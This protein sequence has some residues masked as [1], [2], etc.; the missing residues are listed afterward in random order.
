[1]ED[2][3]EYE[4][5]YNYENE[6]VESNLNSDNQISQIPNKTVDF[7]I[8]KN[9]EIIKKRDIIINKFIESSCL[10]YDEAELVLMKF[11]W[12]YDKLIDIWY[13][14]TEKI[15]IESHIE[16][17]PESIKDIS[18][19]IK[20]NNITG[21]F[22]PICFCDIEKDNFLSLKCNH[23]FCKDCFIEYINNKLL[24]QPMN[25]LETPCP[26]NGCNLYLTRTI[27]RKCI[28][29]KKMQKIFA[30]SVVYNFIRTNKEIKVCPNAYCNYSIRVQDSI[31]KEIICK[32]GYIFC[33]SC[34]EESH[35]PCN[36]E[37]VKKWNS[38]QKKLYKKYSDL[39]K[40][41]DGNL[42]YLDDYNWIKNNTK[43]CPKCQISIEKNQGCN[44]MVC[45]KEAGGCGYQFCW[46]CLG[47]WKHHNY[48]C[49][50]N[51]EK[52]INNELEDKELDRF[53]KYYKGWKIQEY[54]INFNEKIRNKIEEYKNDLVEE[55]NLVQDD[56]KFLEDA[57]ET[58]FNCNRLLK[59]IF[60]FGYFLKEN[61]NI[62]LF[63]Y[64]YHFLHY[65]NDLLLESIELEKLPN[66]IEIQD[67]NLFQK[68]FLEY[69][70]NTFSLIKLIETYKNNL[71]NE[72]DNNL[73][74]KID[75]N[76]II[77]NY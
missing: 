75:Y 13:D 67:K 12:N 60:I 38:F 52:K 1:M 11:N 64:N 39:I 48:N 17:S 57:L 54:N 14:D 29:E 46:N 18:K 23:N 37:M 15:K 5:E 25:I 22:C 76:R 47:S 19:F 10:N 65:Q 27:Y 35:I 31:A 62:T 45:Q 61:A 3:I 7:E 58:I 32:C 2:E 49:Y 72:I 70:D 20:N 26:L 44:H 53:I 43:K 30:K 33:F 50:K 77:Y 55:K 63:E 9:S 71:I 4:E 69:K 51:E 24:T 68:M 74:D 21:N 59:Y 42:K 41:R 40:T 6:C 28:T 16:Q 73:Y 56:V 66:I 8:I 36:C 34:L